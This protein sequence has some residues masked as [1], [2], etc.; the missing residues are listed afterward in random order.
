MGFPPIFQTFFQWITRIIR[1]A[2]TFSKRQKRRI[3]FR[4]TSAPFDVFDATVEGFFIEGMCRARAGYSAYSS[5]LDRFRPEGIGLLIVALLDEAFTLSVVALFALPFVVI[6]SFEATGDVWNHN[7]R[8]AIVFTDPAGV[9]L[10]RRGIWQSNDV[11]LM[12]MPPHVV[13]AVLATEDARF[14]DHFGVDLKGIARAFLENIKAQGVVQGGSTLTQQLAKNLFLSPERSLKRKIHEAFLALWIENRLSKDE[15]LKMYLDRSYLGRGAYGIEAASEVYFGKNIKTLTLAEAALLAGIFK[16]PSTYAPHLNLKAAQERAHLVLRRMFEVGFISYGELLEQRSYLKT[17]TPVP[18][19]SGPNWYLDA[20][21]HEVLTI[22]KKKNITQ[23]Y[24]LVVQT[25]L[26]RA[27]Q[28][29]AQTII[30]DTIKTQGIALKASQGALVSL[31]TNGEVVA[32]VGGTG[33]EKS[34]FNRAMYGFRQP[35]SSFKPFVYLAALR[36]G[37]HPDSIVYDQPVRIGNWSPRNY[38]LRYVGATTLTKALAQSYNSVPVRLMEKVGRKAIIETAYLCGITSTLAPVPSLPLGSNEVT[39]FNLTTAY[40]TFAT[41]GVRLDPHMVLKISRPDGTVLYSYR[42][43]NPRPILSAEIADLNTMLNAVVTEGT[44]RRARLPD[45]VQAG[46]TGTNQDYR[47]A[48]FI[49]YTAHYVTGVW[50][51][52]DTPSQG[53]NRVTGGSLPAMTWKA[54]MEQTDQALW[55][56]PISGIPSPPEQPTGG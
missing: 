35:G 16:A 25:P 55:Q 5:F 12:E 47:D 36:S 27:L 33:Y 24:T 1:L 20:A 44:A 29:H 48:W 13:E 53:M 51:G 37:L 26:D 14:Y 49:G 56:D 43:Q 52:N 21:Y 8:Q 15:I 9:I 38:T 17:I 42:P 7:R 39:L 2:F 46:K 45:A 30:D 19:P 54:Y 3:F 34:Q 10:G 28:R 4:K 6:P 50:Y 18:L 11:P 23:E 31:K 41:G 40:G 22:L 32:I